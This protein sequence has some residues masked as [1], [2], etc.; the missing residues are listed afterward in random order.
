MAIPAREIERDQALRP[1]LRPGSRP[2]AAIIWGP[3][4]VSRPASTSN[5]QRQATHRPGLRC[6]AIVVQPRGQYDHHCK[7]VGQ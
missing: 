6:P 1:G 4:P 2:A 5:W 7:R 3:R